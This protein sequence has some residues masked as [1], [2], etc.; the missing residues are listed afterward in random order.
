M[1]RAV[2]NNLQLVEFPLNGLQAQSRIRPVAWLL[3]L[4]YGQVFFGINTIYR[5]KGRRD[6]GRKVKGLLDVWDR[7]G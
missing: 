4:A 1:I 3:P 6:K 5:P 2:V 7:K